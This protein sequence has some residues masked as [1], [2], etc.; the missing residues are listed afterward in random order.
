MQAVKERIE[1]TQKDV[2]QREHEQKRAQ[3]L[4]GNMIAIHNE[5]LNELEKIH[6]DL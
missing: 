4:L 5:A 3:L 2:L 6:E 1:E